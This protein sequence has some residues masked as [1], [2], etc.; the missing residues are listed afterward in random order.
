MIR[1]SHF[2]VKGTAT[3]AVVDDYEAGRIYP[4]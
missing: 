1:P 2:I 3:E 4:P